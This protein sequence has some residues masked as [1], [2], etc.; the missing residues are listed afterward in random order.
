M[1]PFSKQITF[2]SWSDNSPVLIPSSHPFEANVPKRGA[3]DPAVISACTGRIQPALPE[4]FLLDSYRAHKTPTSAPEG[5]TTRRVVE[6]G[7]RKEEGKR[8]LNGYSLSF[9]DLLFK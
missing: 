5:P 8:N 6:G 1:A 9:Y 2:N 4:T 3:Y 7:R